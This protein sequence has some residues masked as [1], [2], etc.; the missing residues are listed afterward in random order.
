MLS[1]MADWILGHPEEVA[2]LGG[3][4]L[5]AA[6]LIY[7]QGWAG[8]RLALRE[9]MHAA[10]RARRKGLLPLDGPAVMDWVVRRALTDLVPR[11][12]LWLRPVLTEARLRSLAQTLFDH[13]SALAGDWLN[14]GKLDGSVGAPAAEVAAGS[15]PS[16]GDSSPE[17]SRSTHN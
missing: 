8:V 17:G 10:E 4:L 6:A 2:L 3:F 14:D 15:N 9:L 12:P 11:A 13:M 5:T 1:R 7:R 16:A